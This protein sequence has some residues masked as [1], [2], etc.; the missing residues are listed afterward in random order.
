MGKRWRI[1]RRVR[2]FDRAGVFQ[3]DPEECG[4]HACW[5]SVFGR[6][7][8]LEV[9]IGFGKGEFLM[10][11]A[12]SRPRTGFVGI[13]TNKTRLLWTECKVYRAG[14]RNIRLVH[15]DAA[16]LLDVLFA[17]G[18]VNA[19]YMN[20]PDPWPKRRHAKRRLLRDE[21]VERLERLLA[22]GGRLVVVTD[23]ESYALTGLSLLEARAERLENL[24]GPGVVGAELPGHPRTIHEMKFRLQGRRIYFL[25]YRKKTGTR[26]SSPRTGAGGCVSAATGARSSGARSRTNP[27]P[28]GFG[29]AGLELVDRG[30]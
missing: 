14:I 21:V 11:L 13:E 9:E 17:R 22:P 24:F 1:R 27:D 25:H 28:A 4:G 16:R 2:G 6:A 3:V 10:A 7:A 30:G 20:F 23:V 29:P 19:F 18:S 8:P 26:V 5:S 15:G 12:R